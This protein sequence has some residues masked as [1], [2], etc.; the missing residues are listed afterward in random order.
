M[1]VRIVFFRSKK[2]Q[3]VIQIALNF[4]VEQHADWAAFAALDAS[5]FFLIEPVEIGVV[6]DFAGFAQAVVNG[7]VV[8]Q[9]VGVPEKAVPGFRQR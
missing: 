8:G 2:R 6:S 5:S 3:I 4:V 7:L 1:R 9:L